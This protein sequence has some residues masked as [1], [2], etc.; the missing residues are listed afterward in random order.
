MNLL[1][2]S[3]S[4]RSFEMTA[5]VMWE[6]FPSDTNYILP[7]VFL[8]VFILM[9]SVSRLRPEANGATRHGAVSVTHGSYSFLSISLPGE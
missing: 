1:E 4:L 7:E 5:D 8:Q 9:V 3:Q 2:I 6:G